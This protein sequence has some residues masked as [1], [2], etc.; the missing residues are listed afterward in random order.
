MALVA[1]V[2][3]FTLAITF[4]HAGIALVGNMALLVNIRGMVKKF[5]IAK[6]DSIDFITA[7]N[8]SEIPPIIIPKIPDNS[9]RQITPGTPVTK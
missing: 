3:G 1:Y 8:E 4:N 9:T 5:V 7:P 6:R 2:S